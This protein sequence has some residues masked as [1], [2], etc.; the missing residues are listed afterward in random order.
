MNYQKLFKKPFIFIRFTGL[1]IAEFQEL[2]KELKPLWQVAEVARL[3]R[4]NR[5]RKIGGGRN[6]K[7]KSFEDKLFLILIFYKTYLVYEV[8]A[9][10]FGLDASNISKLVAKLEP[11]LAKSRK[12]ELP[13]IKIQRDRSK[14]I[15]SIEEFISLY[16]EAVEFIGDA[17]EQQIPRP[18]DK[19]NK[20]KYYSGKKKRH[21]IKTQIAIEKS[22]QQIIEISPSY[23]GRVHDYTIFKERKLPDKIPPGAP[24]YLDKGY[25]G[26]KKEFPNCNIIIPKKAN[27]WH[28]LSKKDRLENR[29]IGRKRIKIEHA[30]LKCKRFKVLAH[31][32]RHPLESYGQKFKIIAGLVNFKGQNLVTQLKQSIIVKNISQPILVAA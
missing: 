32:Y 28:K 15:S 17:T 16:P 31:I 18:K 12:L 2:A 27:R 26:A 20:K 11:I 9:I 8:L 7:L 5:Q 19:R 23:P 25:D 24:L 29:K 21:T 14:P 3:S 1:S 13:K 22:S 6:Y 30:I 4:P 10:F